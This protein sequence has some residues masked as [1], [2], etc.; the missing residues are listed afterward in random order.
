MDVLSRPEERRDTTESNQLDYGLNFPEKETETPLLNPQDAD[1]SLSTMMNDPSVER[2]SLGYMAIFGRVTFVLGVLFV[3]AG[4][5]VWMF[6][7][8]EHRSALLL[9]VVAMFLAILHN[10]SLEDA[11][12]KPKN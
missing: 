1:A 9:L 10:Y 8:G 6:R 2:T 5:G 3:L 4:L 7:G 12:G 11:N